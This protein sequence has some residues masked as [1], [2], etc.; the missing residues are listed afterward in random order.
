MTE[1]LMR[2]PQVKNVLQTF[3][4]NKSDAFTFLHKIKNDMQLASELALLHSQ[5]AHFG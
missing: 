1:Q 5:S 4:S 2:F 3:A